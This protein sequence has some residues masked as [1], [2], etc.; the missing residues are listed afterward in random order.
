MALNTKFWLRISL[1]N[2]LIVAL[3]GTIMRYKIGFEFP[4][5]DQ[6]HLQHG[7]SHFAFIGWITHTL[8]VLMI[9]IL[10]RDMPGLNTGFYRK[11]IIS[12]LVC[13]YGMVISFALQGYGAFS[14]TFST[15]SVLIAYTFAYML[16]KDLKNLPQRIY[17]TSFTAA[18]WFNIISSVGTFTLAFMMAS[19][20][21]NQNIHLAS[22]YFYLHFQYNGFF[23][24][25]CVGLFLARLHL[26]KLE[27]KQNKQIFWMFFLSCIPAYFLSVLWAKLPLWLLV[28]VTVSAIVQVLA[29]IKLVLSMKEKLRMDASLFKS[30]RYLFLIIVIALS[31]K[32]LLQLG[33]TVPSV[34]KLAFGFRPVVIAYLHLILLAIISV[35]L[36]SYVYYYKLIKVNKLTTI[37]VL[38]FIV[39]VYLNEV[40]LGIQGIASFSYTVVP[41]VNEILF[42]IS[43]L[44]FV[45]LALLLF[46]QRKLKEEAQVE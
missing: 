37:S 36:I 19:H 35:F 20:N 39:G 9:G 38:I 25:A 43:L 17:T 32:F 40:V 18:L 14:I 4:Y 6:K 16:F 7:H 23:M 30:G 22:L 15:L 1:L 10:Q 41:R 8:F 27:F 11:L 21:F 29:W 13:A 45:G 3:F 24:F 26:D 42:F 31:V 2:L 28:L 12:N 5:L 46:S 34:S 33:S 44:I